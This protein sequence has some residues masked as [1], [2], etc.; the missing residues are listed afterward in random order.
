MQIDE[1]VETPDGEVTFKAT[2]S[3]EQVTSMVRWFI[4]TMLSRGAASYTV[5][6][7]DIHKQPEQ[8]Q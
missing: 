4:T 1:V 2:L 8:V 7:P 5:S 3:P 6:G